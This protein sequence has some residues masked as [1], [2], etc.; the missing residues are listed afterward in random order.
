[1]NDTYEIDFYD[2]NTL[3]QVSYNIEDKKTKQ[4]ELRAFGYFKKENQKARY[5]ILS[6][7][8]Q[9]YIIII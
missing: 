9:K 3:F 8:G 7:N 4:R 6:K 5:Q 2:E 1:M